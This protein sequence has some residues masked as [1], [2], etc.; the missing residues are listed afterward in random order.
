[1]YIEQLKNTKVNNVLYTIGILGIL[2]FFGLN[3]LATFLG[4]VDTN[5]MLKQSIE[6]FGK[7]ITFL[8]LI[9]PFAFLLLGLLLWIKFVLKQPLVSLT[10]S[11]S[12]IDWKRF[13]FMFILWGGFLTIVTVISYLLYPEDFIFQF[14]INKFLPF[15]FIAL[16]FIPLQT[17]FEEYFFRGNF[18]Q[19]LGYKTNSRLIP[20][21]VTSVIF[22]LMHLSNP[23]VGAMGLILMIFYI[24]TGF[25]L[26][27]FVLMDEGLELS[28]GFHAANNLIGALLVTSTT[29]VFQTDSILVDISSQTNIAPLLAQ[30][31]IVYP[32]LLLICAKKYNWSNWKSNIFGKL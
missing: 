28:L 7:N 12:K 21:V 3:I 14:D 23:E 29:S 31:F 5:E 4:D 10:T 1:M 22:G 19:F 16:I 32:I 6:V 11:R 15:L 2:S 27:I 30:V 18:F 25:L 24:G 20:L 9:V 26:G 13:W 8:N 17:S